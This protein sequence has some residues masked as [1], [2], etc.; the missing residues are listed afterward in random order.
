M[1]SGG[2]SFHHSS[3]Y[4]ATQGHGSTTS[5][6]VSSIAGGEGSGWVE[7]TGANTSTEGVGTEASGIGEAVVGEDDGLVVEGLLVV[8][9]E[10]TR[11]GLGVD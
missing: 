1:I 8:G 4:S 7:P 3:S 5:V 2:K 6:V 11:T 10:V 9:D